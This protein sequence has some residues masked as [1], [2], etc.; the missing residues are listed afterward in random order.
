[1]CIRDS[2]QSG[3]ENAETSPNHICSIVMHHPGW[4]DW[5]GV[6]KGATCRGQIACISTWPALS[7]GMSRHHG[8]HPATA[9]CNFQKCSAQMP[10]PLHI[11][12]NE[13]GRAQGSKED[14]RKDSASSRA[15]DT[16]RNH[17]ATVERTRG[18]YHSSAHKCSAA[19]SWRSEG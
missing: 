10:A 14:G 7:P 6:N 11:E 12:S 13:S 5:L 3:V 17:L 19:S 16:S 18:M 1:M 8:T 15:P 4:Y 9:I 2:A